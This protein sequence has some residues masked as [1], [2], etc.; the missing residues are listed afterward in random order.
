MSTKRPVDN[1][2]SVPQKKRSL[3]A[4]NEDDYSLSLKVM[5][6]VLKKLN[7]KTQ[8]EIKSAL[9]G[10]DDLLYAAI[11]SQ[12]EV[13]NEQYLAAKVKSTEADSQTKA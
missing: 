12:D 11:H 8:R 2:A 10:I 5:P 13:T 1:V 7:S 9:R 3:F 4:A 6:S